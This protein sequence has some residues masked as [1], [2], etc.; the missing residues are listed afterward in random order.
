MNRNLDIAF[1]KLNDSEKII[2]NLIYLVHT[3]RVTNDVFNHLTK[4]D[5]DTTLNKLPNFYK[6]QLLDLLKHY[7]ENK[8]NTM[9]VSELKSIPFEVEKIIQVAINKKKESKKPTIL[10]EKT[11]S[12]SAAGVKK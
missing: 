7:W 9:E 6:K 11:K 12:A 8:I 3:N 1:P 10:H 5:V 2:I 4:K